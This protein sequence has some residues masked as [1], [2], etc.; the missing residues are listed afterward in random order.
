MKH[1]DLLKEIEKGRYESVYLFVGEEEFLK[2]EALRQ[3]TQALI[4]PSVK[5]FNY[6]LL[7]GGETDAVT[8]VDIAASY[9]MMAER[10]LV[11]FRDIHHCSPKDRKVLLSYVANPV[12]TTCLV[13]AGPKVDM[14]K[15]FYRELSKAATTVQFWPLFDNQIPAWIRKR[16]QEQGKQISSDALRILQNF[17]GT[18][19][20]EMANEIDKLGIYLYERETIEK[21]DVETVVGATKV[22]SVFDLADS[23]AERKLT[24]SFQILHSLLEAGE[25][26]VGI[27][28]ILA[29]RFFTL[30]KVYQLKKNQTSAEEIARKAKIRPFLVSSYLRQSGYLL[31]VELERAFQLLLEADMNLKSS[32]QNP[33]LILELLV[34]R[35]CRFSQND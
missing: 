35:L 34:Y 14:R 4:D 16:V 29:R 9:P 24:D 7:Y 11:I 13:L 1:D 10:R 31:P 2:E 15:G 26:G 23:V 3:I 20:R 19:L 8:V 5:E 30:A 21:R 22:N 17:V 25:S 6:D 27:V 12:Q 33:K 28:W 18:N 32:Y